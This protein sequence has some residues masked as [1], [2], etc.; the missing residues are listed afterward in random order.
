MTGSRLLMLIRTPRGTRQRGQSF[1][2][3]SAV[4]ARRYTFA[5]TSYVFTQPLTRT[6]F[7]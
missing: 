1:A 7:A 4:S 3:S 2:I 6:F 5:L